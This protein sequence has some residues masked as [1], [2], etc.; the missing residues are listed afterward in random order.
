MIR[1][2]LAILAL[3]AST[4]ALA[5]DHSHKAWDELLK[6][7]VKYVQNGNAS[8]VNLATR[9]AQSIKPQATGQPLR[10]NWDT[11]IMVSNAQCSIVFA[12]GRSS[13]GT[14]SSPVTC[15]L[16]LQPTR[17]ESKP[18]IPIPPLTPLEVQRP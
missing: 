1:V 11:P 2:L 15:V 6:K 9:Q 5:L 10:W 4:A 3:A 14:E 7:H 8:R 18:G 17:N 13:A 16:V 12:G